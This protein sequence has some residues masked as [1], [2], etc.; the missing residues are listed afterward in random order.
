MTMM[1][2]ETALLNSDYTYDPQAGSFFKEDSKGNL[3]TNS[4]N[5]F[6]IEVIIVQSISDEVVDHI[7]LVFSEELAVDGSGQFLRGH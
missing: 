2:F 4:I 1:T 3:A 7:P 5:I 6:G